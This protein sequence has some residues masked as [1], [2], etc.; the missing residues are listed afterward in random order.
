MTLQSID[1]TARAKAARLFQRPERVSGFGRGW[2]RLFATH[3]IV[4]AACISQADAS[5]HREAPLIT[6]TPKLDG[7]DFYMFRSYE[8]GRDGYVTIIANYLPL[9]D[10]YGGPNY[11]ELDNAGLYEIHIDNDGDGLDD[12]TFQFR[13]TNTRENLAVN[14]GGVSVPIPLVQLG[15]IGVGGN[16]ADIGNLNV[17]E[18]YT[19]SVI[20]RGPN[21]LPNSLMTNVATR[22][23]VLEKPVDN[24]GF[25]TLPDYAAYAAAHIYNVQIPG[26]AG[27]GRVFVGQRK[28]PFV[29]NLGETFDLINIAN[30]IGEANNNAGRDDIADKNVTSLVLEVPI[31]CLVARDPVIGAWT[32]ASSPSASFQGNAS[33]QVSRLGMP[34]VNE[35]VIGLPDKD[36]FNASQPSNDSTFLKYV[37]N[38]SFPTIVQVVFGGAVKAPTL[39]PRSDLVATFL[40]GISGINKPANVRPAEMLRLNTTTPVTPAG[41]QNRLGV[42]GGDNAGF[43]N[44]RRPGDDVVDVTLRVAM[45]RLISLGLFG[46][47]AQAPSGNLDFTDGAYVDAT[48]FDTTFPYLKTP[49]AGS[50][51]AAQ[52]SV[53]LPPRA[54]LPGLQA[55]SAP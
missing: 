20:R 50:P 4:A 2:V 41:R 18:S 40:T 35:L 8:P 21:L 44:G 10:P 43:P 55:V 34:L 9:Q 23:T 37:T 47:P 12:I 53:P 17:R 14:V 54:V 32:S 31:S 36:A 46:T 52:P 28:D 16:P 3:A 38:P 29:V 7:T 48:F 27:N 39:F 30:P 24:I 26:C 19:V 25:K 15:T 49:L 22:T 33:S 51:G 42:I 5:S 13:F 45:G 1:R 6:S 11:F